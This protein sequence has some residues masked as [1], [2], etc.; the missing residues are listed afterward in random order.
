M[1]TLKTIATSLL[2]LIVAA[3]AHANIE[4][5]WLLSDGAVLQRNE[6]IPIWGSAPAN[7]TLKVTFAGESREVKADSGGHW[8][9]FFS[10]RKAGGPYQLD[11]SSENYSRTVHDLLLGDVWVCSG[12]SNM[13]WVVRDSDGAESEITAANHPQI[14]HFKVPRSWSAEPATRLAG[15]DWQAATPEHLGDFT[16]VGW[17]FAKRIHSTTGVPIGLL[18]TTWGGSRIEAWMSPN[19]L[20][21]APEASQNTLTKL[22]TDG[23]ARAAQV[24]QL[25]SRWPGAIVEKIDQGAADWSAIQIDESDWLKIQVPGLWES[26]QF[27]GVDGIIWYRTTFTLTLEEAKADI[28]LSLG[29]IDDNDITW[30]NGHQVGATNAYDALRTYKV[31]ARY[32]KPGKN[33][34]AIRVEDTGGGGGIYASDDLIYIETLGGTRRSLVGQWNIKVDK[35]T[36]E[37]Q[38]NMHHVDTAL[39]NKMLHPLFN[40]PVKGVLWYQGE[41]NANSEPE[42]TAYK[43][44]FPALIN[45][46]RASWN[47]P[48]MPFYWV[49]L[50]NFISGHDTEQ[51]SPWAVLRESQTAALALKNSGQAITIDIG[52]PHDIHPTDKTTVGERLALIALNKTYG[53]K[54]TAFRGPV[55]RSVKRKKDHLVLNFNANHKLATKDASSTVHGFEVADENGRFYSV[56]GTIKNKQVLLPLRTNATAVRYAWSDNPES[57]NLMDA[58]GL[59]AEPFRKKF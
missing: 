7:S 36:V 5:P 10:P 48:N 15:G 23:E 39:Y 53:Q 28:T 56:E 14:R 24:K 45:D 6:P 19:A 59:P 54:K 26:Q 13:E 32:L 21:V 16:A 47:K 1:T 18:N 35:A 42:A 51:S 46:W 49:Q 33:Q 8:Q 55:V 20:G 40:I 29:R 38:D 11:I 44:Q 27:A 37:I 58:E 25:L 22:R 4:L 34:I 17:Y 43:Q 57:A 30:V 52:N 3:Q 12:Q 2:V 50:A 31:P 41:S 9:T